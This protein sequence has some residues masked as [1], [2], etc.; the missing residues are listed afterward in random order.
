MKNFNLL[1]IALFTSITVT[2][3]Q[4]SGSFQV[5]GFLDPHYICDVSAQDQHLDFKNIN[6]ND[7]SKLGARSHSVNGHISF[8]NCDLALPGGGTVSG[9]DLRVIPGTPSPNDQYWSILN[10]PNADYLGIDLRINNQKILP[11]QG[12]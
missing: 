11:L 5:N 6:A 1:L 7:I 2:H 9:I 3:A 12:K 10:K 4:N 8:M